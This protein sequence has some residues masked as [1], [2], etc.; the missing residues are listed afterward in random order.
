MIPSSQDLIDSRLNQFA[1]SRTPI[2]PV[3]SRPSDLEYLGNLR[4]GMNGERI[5]FNSN[6]FPQRLPD[7][8][9]QFEGVSPVVSVF[10]PRDYRLLSADPFGKFLLS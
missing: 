2:E 5:E 3:V 4:F 6:P 7:P 10:D 9:Q 8:L 1:N